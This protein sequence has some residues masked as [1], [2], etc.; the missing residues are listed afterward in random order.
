MAAIRNILLPTDFSGYS[1]R[2]FE[3]ALAWATSFGA[4]IHMLHIVTVHNFDPFNPELG[5]PEQGMNEHMRESSENAMNKIAGSMQAEAP[6]ITMETR[7]GFSPWNEILDTAAR[8]DVDMIV[9]ATHGRKGLQKLFLGSTTEKV[10]EHASCPVL[11]LRPRE[12]EEMPE[13]G[14]I[15]S[16]L[17]PS[18]F[19]DE[20]GDAAPV[21]LELARHF[22]AK[23]N[24]FHCVEQDVPPPYYAAGITSIFELNEDILAV[25]R[26]H[27]AELLTDDEA[28]VIDHEFIVREGRSPFEIV[29]F[30]REAAVDL[31]VMATHGYSGFE[32][33]LLGSTTDR[34]I[35]N[36]PCP[37]LVIR[38]AQ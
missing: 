34:V 35:R 8:L 4:D 18:D 9:M 19:S 17:L 30:A 36:A 10:V 27:L 23:L 16:I 11:L 25:S 2:A 38:S 20:A 33:A 28:D 15:A 22:G 6:T 32:Q 31:I 3:H 12:N 7:T 5:F 1:N 14:D 13:A 26:K 21:A 29:A 37:L 24:L